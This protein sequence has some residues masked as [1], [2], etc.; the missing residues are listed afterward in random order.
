MSIVL[1]CGDMMFMSRIA[2]AAKQIGVPCTTAMS[3]ASLAD[4]LV[5]G[6]RLVA[7]DLSTPGLEPAVIV[8]MGGVVALIVLSI[9]LPILQIN[10]L[11]MG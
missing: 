1:L 6:T 11:A 8:V 4:K 10:T 9:L 2:G 5:E 7:I 3:P